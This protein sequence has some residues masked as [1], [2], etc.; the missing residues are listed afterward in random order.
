[1]GNVRAIV[2][3]CASAILTL[4]PMSHGQSQMQTPATRDWTRS[5]QAGRV[6]GIV[7][8]NSPDQAVP[9][10]LVRLERIS[11]QRRHYMT[12]TD[13]AGRFTLIL[14]AGG[15]RLFVDKPGFVPFAPPDHAERSAADLVVN[16]SNVAHVSVRLQRLGVISGSV[17]D[18]HGEP[19]TDVR[20]QATSG[21]NTSAVGRSATTDDRGRY[22]I[23]GL[24]PGRYYVSATPHAIITTTCAQTL[25][26]HR[27]RTFYPQSYDPHAAEIVEV[28]GDDELGKIDI[29]LLS[30]PDQVVK[31]V[32]LT[33]IAPDT[34]A[35]HVFTSADGQKSSETSPQTSSIA[36]VVVNQATGVAVGD[37]K[38]LLTQLQGPNVP[39]AATAD[40]TGHFVFHSLPPGKY[41]LVAIR[42]GFRPSVY[43]DERGGDIVLGRNERLNNL[44][45]RAVPASA[46]E[47]TVTNGDGE[48]V[49]G[50]R[51]EAL[52]YVYAAGKRRMEVAAQSQTDDLGAYRLHGL[53]AG[54]YF[55]RAIPGADDVGQSTHPDIAPNDIP[56][57][58]PSGSEV[59]NGG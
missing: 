14:V 5:P 18:E 54:C 35:T 29:Q 42:N 7:R 3:F 32:D 6:V 59:V 27:V 8:S 26:E 9:R 13:Q 40:A 46:I 16:P 1:M 25:A 43:E 12:G 19:L 58:Y 20:V 57:F 39:H 30:L 24:M 38:L 15:Y 51:V 4:L 36:G 41:R 28:R 53:G 45:M 17:I 11:G 47:G 22:R 34:T 31:I 37:V 44:M 23:Y 55:I 10:A 56:T 33:T 50:V 49:S 21:N 52:R 48:Q 2:F